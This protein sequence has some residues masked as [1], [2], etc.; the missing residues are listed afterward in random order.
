MSSTKSSAMAADAFDIQTF[1][2]VLAE[3]EAQ[4]SKNQLVRQTIAQLSTAFVYAE[5]TNVETNRKLWD[6]YAK[7]WCKKEAWLTEMAENV[8]Q[9]IDRL[10]HVG[11]EWS[12]PTS[13]EQALAHFLF[14]YVLNS[15][16]VAEIGSG[17]GRV[18]SKVFTK[19]KSITCFDVSL[20]MLKNAKATL[21][22]VGC[23]SAKYV[24]LKGSGPQEIPR[25]YDQLF[26]FIYA[27]DVFV[28][29]D[30]HT[31][32]HYFL[33]MHRMLK[34]NGHIFVSTANLLSPR[35]WDRFAK[36][37]RF[38]VG[39]FYFVS[40]DIVRQLAT[41]A[42]FD[43]VKE[44]PQLAEDFP[45]NIY[46]QRDYLVLLRKVE[47]ENGPLDICEEASAM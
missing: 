14:P 32:W 9:P 37:S 46:F 11:D 12:D 5:P 20:E 18:A 28:H 3:K 42:G 47:S 2:D 21:D 38:T 39:G 13:L 4:K 33:A 22:K 15:M 27:F 31:I 34:P 45:E 8:G 1:Q 16:E 36:Q 17:G 35:G 24:H 23:Q 26:H 7:S 41:K 30:L 40:P 43:I 19:V 10:V 44:S 29:L 25:R 6:E